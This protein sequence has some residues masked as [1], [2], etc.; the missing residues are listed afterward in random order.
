[1][2]LIQLYL[3]LPF[4]FNENVSAVEMDGRKLET[5][6]DGMIEALR[7]QGDQAAIFYLIFNF[8]STNLRRKQRGPNSRP[9]IHAFRN[10]F[11]RFPARHRGIK[12]QACF[13]N[14]WQR[15]LVCVLSPS[16]SV[17]SSNRLRNIPIP[18]QWLCAQRHSISG[19]VSPD[20]ES[21][22]RDLLQR[23]QRQ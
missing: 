4:G 17:S 21:P 10:F 20:V 9:V 6:G 5:A 18:S 14:I 23:R 2:P 11:L 1:M 12:F 15:F 19:S 13:Y 16:I 3:Q 8:K 7:Q 22:M